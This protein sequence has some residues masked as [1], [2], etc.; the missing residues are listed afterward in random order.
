MSNNC[1]SGT[2]QHRD[3]VLKYWAGACYTTTCATKCPSFSHVEYQTNRKSSCVWMHFNSISK[4][5]PPSDKKDDRGQFEGLSITKYSNAL[6]MKQRPVNTGHF[7][8][9]V[10]G[11]HLTKYCIKHYVVLIESFESL[12]LF[13]VS[14]GFST[15][16]Q[17]VLCLL[18]FFH[19]KSS[20]A[21]PLQEQKGFFIDLM[22]YDRVYH[23]KVC[24]IIET[25]NIDWQDPSL[26]S[27]FWL[28]FKC[29]KR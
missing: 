14:S 26:E 6:L 13:Q 22:T 20:N 18:L 28:W 5:E 29:G 17:L 23:W 7:C 2:N 4:S 16:T 3:N 9:P 1:S 12:C 8:R 11:S 19:Y 21:I 25:I 27:S 15:I 24:L 10:S